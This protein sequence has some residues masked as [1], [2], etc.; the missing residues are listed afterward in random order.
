MGEPSRQVFYRGFLF[1]LRAR[2]DSFESHGER[3]HTAFGKAL[4]AAARVEHMPF[5]KRVADLLE[6]KDP[7]FGR[8]RGAEE[9]VLEG[10]YALLL[11]LDAPRYTQARFNISKARAAQEFAEMAHADVYAAMAK[12]F[13]ECW[14]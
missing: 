9:M 10:L 7:M 1:A 8:Y 11:T 13:H 2:C 3:F 6:G 12:T 14:P 5:P 4:D